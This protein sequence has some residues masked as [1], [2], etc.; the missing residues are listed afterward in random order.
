VSSCE[1]VRP[2]IEAKV[3]ELCGGGEGAVS[4]GLQVV[5]GRMMAV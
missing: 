1:T 4:C 3:L 5:P 2:E